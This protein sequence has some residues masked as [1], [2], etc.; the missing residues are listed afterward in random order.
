MVIENVIWDMDEEP[1]GN[2]QHVAEHGL[3]KEDVEE[4][5]FGVHELDTS[6]SSGR[7]IAFGFTAAGEYICVVFERVDDDTVYPV[8]A[9]VLED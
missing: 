2:V 9:Y 8:T 3:T 4:V 7:P 6:H 1:E 5:L